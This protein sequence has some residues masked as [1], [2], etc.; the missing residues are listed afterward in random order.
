MDQKKILDKWLDDCRNKIDLY[1]NDIIMVEKTKYRMLG[2][3]QFSFA[4]EI[5]DIEEYD[6]LLSEVF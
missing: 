2:M 3:L 5:I 1:H 6:K 4:I